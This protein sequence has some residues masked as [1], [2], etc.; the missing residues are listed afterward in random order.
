MQARSKAEQAQIL[1]NSSSDS[2]S[3]QLGQ[4]HKELRISR[5]EGQV[6]QG[7]LVTALVNLQRKREKKRQYKVALLE[8]TEQLQAALVHKDVRIGELNRRIDKVMI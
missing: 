8:E 2:C 6:L 5:Q 4:V 7:Q 1:M 3:R